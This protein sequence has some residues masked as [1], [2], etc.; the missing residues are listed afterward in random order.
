MAGHW[1]SSL[2]VF[3]IN[4]CPVGELVQMGDNR[5]HFPRK[6]RNHSK[7]LWEGAHR[8][9]LS[10]R[11]VLYVFLIFPPEPCTG[12]RGGVLFKRQIQYA[13]FSISLVRYSSSFQTV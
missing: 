2:G 5:I 12:I 13:W 11:E 4:I 10:T 9:V 8:P 7:S 3:G 1:D 6:F